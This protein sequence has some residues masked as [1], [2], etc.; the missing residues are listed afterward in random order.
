MR[1]VF[2]YIEE[3][4]RTARP[5]YQGLSRFQLWKK[6]LHSMPKLSQCLGQPSVFESSTL[7][8]AVTVEDLARYIVGVYKTLSDHVHSNKSPA[9]Y[10]QAGD[11]LEIVEGQLSKRQ[12]RALQCVCLAFGFPAELRQNIDSDSD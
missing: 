11:K 1:G 5:G 12:C 2:D 9:E 6:V 8:R 3:E 10:R 4:L 7:P